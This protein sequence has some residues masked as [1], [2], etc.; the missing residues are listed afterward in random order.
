MYDVLGTS[1]DVLCVKPCYYGSPAL[2]GFLFIIWTLLSGIPVFFGILLFIRRRTMD[3]F[4]SLQTKENRIMLKT[5]NVSL[6][7]TITSLLAS[8]VFLIYSTLLISIVGDWTLEDLIFLLKT[9]LPLCFFLLLTLCS[10]LWYRF[11]KRY[12][13]IDTNDTLVTEEVWVPSINY[14]LFTISLD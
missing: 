6:S 4:T 3:Y 12:G 2:T 10:F 9:L 13:V 11:R 5:R 7:L 14:F 1:F 8:I